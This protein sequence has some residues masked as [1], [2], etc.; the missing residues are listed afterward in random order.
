MTRQTGVAR[1]R[2]RA[3][4]AAL[5]FFRGRR[6]LE[7]LRAYWTARNNYP[8]REEAL[9]HMGLAW[10]TFRP[11]ALELGRRLVAVGTFRR[12]DDVFYLASE[13]LAVA[14]AAKAGGRPVPRLAD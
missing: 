8:A 9:F 3:F 4:A 11:L 14:I 2:R 1:T 10:S 13:D 6:R 12:P 7:F 5:R